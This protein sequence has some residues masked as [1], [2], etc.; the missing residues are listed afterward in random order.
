MLGEPVEVA[1][2]RPIDFVSDNGKTRFP[3]VHPNLVLAPGRWARLQKGEAFAITFEAIE[4]AELSASGFSLHP[5]DS[6]GN[7]HQPTALGNRRVDLELLA[8]RG[9]LANRE[10]FLV[11]LPLRER[12]HQV[13]SGL[14]LAATDQDAGSLSVLAM[15]GIR[16]LR[17]V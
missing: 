12:A 9:A 15:K 5:V 13:A 11:H 1:F 7:P 10:V 4:H 16:G 6:N 2:V 14:R 8:P 3:Q 17:A